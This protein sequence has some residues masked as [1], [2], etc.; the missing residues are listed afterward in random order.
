VG[1]HVVADGLRLTQAAAVAD[2]QPAVRAQHR[3]VVG[4]VLGV[5]RA[6]AD[7]DQGHAIAVGGDQVVGRHLVAV[8]DHAGHQGLASPWS[9]PF[10]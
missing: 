6:D 2:H 5:G 10:R 3:Q 9:M 8:P 1:Q 7:V 4:D